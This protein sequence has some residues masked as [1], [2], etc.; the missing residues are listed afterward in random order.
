MYNGW[1]FNQYK[2]VLQVVTSRTGRQTFDSPFF[3]T[4]VYVFSKFS[5]RVQLFTVLQQYSLLFLSVY[6]VNINEK[7]PLYSDKVQ[8]VI[9]KTLTD[10]K[11][12]KR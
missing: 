1:L 3:C 9:T 12:G 2:G 7:V 4:T 5:I 6:E 8:S 10:L 11:N